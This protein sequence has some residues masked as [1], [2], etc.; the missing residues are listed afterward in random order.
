MGTLAGRHRQHRFEGRKCLQVDSAAGALV[1]DIALT[2][3][4]ERGN[5]PQL[6]GLINFTGWA[7]SASWK[8]LLTSAKAGSRL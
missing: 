1:M 6:L 5:E 3:G 8:M 2:V 4:L 7:L